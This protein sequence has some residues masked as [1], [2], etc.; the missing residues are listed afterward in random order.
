MADP[1]NGPDTV[2]QIVE[3]QE[4]LTAAAS[5]LDDGELDE[6]TELMQAALDTLQVAVNNLTEA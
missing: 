4:N 6:A 1:T 3:V 5:H 2:E